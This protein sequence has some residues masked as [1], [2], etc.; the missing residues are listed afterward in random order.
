V[1]QGRKKV[2][3]KPNWQSKRFNP[4]EFRVPNS[5][6]ALRRQRGMF[7][8]LELR[9]LDSQAALRREQRGRR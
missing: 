3:R 2:A 6:A 9:V 5:Q 4:P 1:R 7:N 8:P